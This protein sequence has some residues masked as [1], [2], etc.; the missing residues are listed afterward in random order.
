[1]TAVIQATCPGCKKMLRI[2]PDWIHQAI[3]CKHCGLVMTPGS[4]PP[5]QLPVR[6]RLQAARNEARAGE[7]QSAA[8]SK[9]HAVLPPTAVSPA[10]ATAIPRRR[11]QFRSIRLPP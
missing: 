4:P 10:V 3:R 11:R 5:R 2:P 8:R 6:E 9:G 7:N 1:M